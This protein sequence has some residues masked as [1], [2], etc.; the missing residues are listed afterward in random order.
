MRKFVKISLIIVAVLVVTGFGFIIAGSVTAGGMGVL[1]EQLRSGD[2]NFGNWHFEDGVYYKGNMEIDVTD[3]VSG[4]LD[5]LPVGSEQMENEFTENIVNLEIDTDLSNLTICN[6]DVEH[7]RVS[8]NEGYI[9][10]YE[11]EVSG[12][13]LYI[14]Y[15]VDGHSFKQG[16]K[17]LVEVP[18]HMTLKNISV[19]TDLGE[20]VIQE[21]SEPL[22]GLCINSDLGNILVNDCKVSGNAEVTAA[23]GN[24]T[25]KDACFENI[26]LSAD[27]GNVEFAGKVEG[28]ITAQ[29][30]MGNV[31][32]ELEGK[33]ED[34]NIELSA[35]MGEVTWEGHKQSGMSGSVSLYQENA[36]GDIILNCDMGN[37]ELSFR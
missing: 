12:D 28:D 31:E 4:T 34:Y 37:V 10:Y 8:L 27:M 30:D 25:V 23:M 32:V 29:A 7:V 36:C 11:A 21:L 2:L 13:T 5:L 16:P 26:E 20:I 35:D 22:Q 14:S 24:I 17:I 18:K 3:M 6:A 15:D 33:K 19:D 9:R 1:K